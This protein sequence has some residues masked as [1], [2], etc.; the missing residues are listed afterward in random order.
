MFVPKKLNAFL[1]NRWWNRHETAPYGKN[2]IFRPADTT[3]ACVCLMRVPFHKHS[4]R[5][6]SGLRDA[7]TTG[8]RVRCVAGGGR[9]RRLHRWA[10]LERE[11]ELYCRKGDHLFGGLY[12]SRSCLEK[13]LT[14]SAPRTS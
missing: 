4:S 8:W 10:V 5:F 2:E 14:L 1:R 11:E 9:S 7:L 12:G 6:C 13:A 3:C